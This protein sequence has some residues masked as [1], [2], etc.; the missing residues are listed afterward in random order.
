MSPERLSDGRLV[1]RYEGREYEIPEQCPHRGAPLAEGYLNGPFLRCAW[2]GATFDVRTGDRL[3]G[4][5]CPKLPAPASAGT[6]E[7]S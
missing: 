1:V 6:V 5:A 4:P 2:H 7:R 3:R